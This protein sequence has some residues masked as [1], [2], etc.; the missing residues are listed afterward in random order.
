MYEFL[1]WGLTQPGL[2]DYKG[3]SITRDSYST[4]KPEPNG[5]FT[6]THPPRPLPFSLS[7]SDPF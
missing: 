7:I 4:N 5:E 2:W 3:N 1:G 6:L